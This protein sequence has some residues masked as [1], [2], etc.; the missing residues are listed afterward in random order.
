MFSILFD[1]ITDAVFFLPDIVRRKR[2]TRQDWSGI[3]E[4]KKV[5]ARHFLSTYACT[6]VF[7]TDDGKSR[8]LR[9]GKDDFDL[10]QVGK[11][12]IKKAGTYLPDTNPA[13]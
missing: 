9:M 11:R 13:G 5:R 6:V 3:V 10:Y 2:E 8:K 7:R 4:K 12:Y 1:L